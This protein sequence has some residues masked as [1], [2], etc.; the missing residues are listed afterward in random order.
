MMREYK[1]YFKISCEEGAIVQEAY[2]EMLVGHSE[3]E[4]PY[5]ELTKAFTLSPLE[6]VLGLE[7]GQITIITP[8][9][10]E[11]RND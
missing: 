4:I 9:E 11:R 7:P 3:K 10:Y 2:G 5:E 1:I 6:K 8:E